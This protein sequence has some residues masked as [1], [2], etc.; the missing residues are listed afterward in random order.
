MQIRIEASHLPGRSSSAFA[1]AVDI[2][3]GVQAKD[4]PQEVTAPHAG[5]AP[6][7]RWTLECTT[8]PGPDGT[9][10]S[11]PCI[12]H[13]FGSRFVYLS[14]TTA[15]EGGT[16]TMFRRAKLMLDAVSPDVLEAAVR[17]GRLTARLRLTDGQGQPLCGAVRPPLVTWTAEQ[18]D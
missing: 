16:A 9:V 4:R 17:S 18:A 14:W 2:H 5:D 3:V 15:D 13:R 10:V 11:G 1:D 6:S 12:Q 7:A 8:A